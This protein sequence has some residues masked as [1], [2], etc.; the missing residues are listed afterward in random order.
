MKVR[1]S[2]IGAL[3]VS[4]TV[5]GAVYGAAA[6]LTVNGGTIQQGTDLSLECQSDPIQVDSWGINSSDDALTGGKA[7]FVQ[8]SGVDDAA[9]AG[10]RLMG[11]VEDGDGDLVGYLTTLNPGTGA[12]NTEAAVVEIAAF[13]GP[14]GLYD[15]QR[16]DGVYKFQLITPSGDH[17]IEPGSAKGL[18]LWIEGSAGS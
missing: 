1:G 4:G 11:R 9:C 14:A 18:K 12:A 6:S 17:G 10:N 13:T 8:I 2:I 15:A 16:A 3:L 7:T 5:F